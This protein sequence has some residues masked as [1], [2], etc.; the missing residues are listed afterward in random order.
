MGY[1]K[2]PI[3]IASVDI[4]PTEMCF[5]Q[6]LPIKMENS[7]EFRIPKNL[8]FVNPIL[9]IIYGN[10]IPYFD[11]I[12]LTVKHQYVYPGSPGNRP[13]WHVDGYGSEGM[14][15]NYIWHSMNPTQF[16]IQ[17]FENIPDDDFESME[18]FEDQVRPDS[19][20][21][22][23]NGS[24]LLLDDLVVHRVNPNIEEGYRTFIKISESKN[25]F[26]L[27]GNAHNFLFDYSWEMFDRKEVR[28][29]DNKD[30]A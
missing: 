14:D 5:V 22:Y 4:E 12:Y 23:G 2:A 26:N 29:L 13:G 16:A 20:T 18:A 10:Y 21:T 8:E 17:K 19:I 25:R 9:E 7:S 3:Y 28:N 11:Y 30:F 6:Y 15:S 24:I 27:V 1:G